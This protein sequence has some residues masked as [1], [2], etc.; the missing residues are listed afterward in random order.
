M[1]T[2]PEIKA[3]LKQLDEITLLE[4]L[5]I[6]GEDLVDRFEDIIEDKAEQLDNELNQW[7]EENAE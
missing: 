6:S 3:Q 4:L 5:C 7:F 1:R 2:L